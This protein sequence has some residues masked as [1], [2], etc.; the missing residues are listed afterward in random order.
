MMKF[1][2]RL[3][4]PDVNRARNSALTIGLAYFIGGLLPLS[5]YFFTSTPSRGLLFSAMITTFSLFV[6]G[7]FKSR[8]TGQ[9]AIKGAFKVTGIGLVAAAAAY[10]VA[11]GFDRLFS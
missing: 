10:F 6:F 8:I 4:K 5:A 3:E 11:I 7:Y 9:N 2:L 1:E